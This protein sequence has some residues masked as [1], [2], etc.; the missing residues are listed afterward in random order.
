MGMVAL[1]FGLGDRY[2]NF[3]KNVVSARFDTQNDE[4]LFQPP[5]VLPKLPPARHY[6]VFGKP[7]Y[8]DSIDYLDK[9]QCK[10]LYLNV[11]TELERGFDDILVARK[12][13]PCADPPKRYAYQQLSGKISS[14]PRSNTVFT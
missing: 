12:H 13:D 6:F 3:S 5:F 14:K 8:T 11:K 1:P 9:E 7:F 2:A 10:M 4:E